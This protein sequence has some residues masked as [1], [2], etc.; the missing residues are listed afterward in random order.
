[1]ARAQGGCRRKDHDDDRHRRDPCHADA[2]VLQPV[3]KQ[4]HY[5]RQSAEDAPDQDREPEQPAHAGRREGLPHE[6]GVEPEQSER[7]RR[8]EDDGL[9]G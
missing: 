9:D 7:E 1:L 4:Q 5:R 6:A 2:K 3:P 8:H